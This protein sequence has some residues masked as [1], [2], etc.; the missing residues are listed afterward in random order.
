MAAEISEFASYFGL[1][2]EL[3]SEVVVDAQFFWALE[4]ECVPTNFELQGYRDPFPLC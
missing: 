1:I 3:V 4:V 2:E